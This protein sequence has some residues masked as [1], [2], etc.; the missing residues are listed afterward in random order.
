MKVFSVMV[1]F[2]KQI[3]NYYKD[4]DKID[5]VEVILVS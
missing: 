4:V 3:E 1:F 2:Y 5:K